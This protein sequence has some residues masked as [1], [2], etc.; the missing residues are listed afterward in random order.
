MSSR[1]ATHT[2]H[3]D[4]AK[5]RADRSLLDSLSAVSIAIDTMPEASVSN[6]R[7]LSIQFMR[8]DAMLSMIH[9]QILDARANL[10]ALVAKYGM[11]DA[12]VET[13]T[14][15]LS[16]LEAAY[17]QRLALLRKRREEGSRG[18]KTIEVGIDT[19]RE[20]MRAPEKARNSNSLW[21]L[22]VLAA[23]ERKNT[24]AYAPA[25]TPSAA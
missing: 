14:Y 6:A 12:M 17:A 15:N 5:P 10:A 16:A 20:P 25:L 18:N 4:G 9:K 13:L 11:S 1:Q 7:S 24:S 8:T 22:W 3:Q 23:A 2:K 19:R 21:W